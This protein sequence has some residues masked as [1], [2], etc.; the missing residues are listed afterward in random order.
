MKVASNRQF[1]SESNRVVDPATA[2]AI[3]AGVEFGLSTTE[4]VQNAMKAY[5]EIKGMRL[6]NQLKAA[7]IAKTISDMACDAVVIIN[8]TPF[9]VEFYMY[10]KNPMAVCPDAMRYGGQTLL[11]GA[12]KSA[13]ATH[14]YYCYKGR[15]LALYV[16]NRKPLHTANRGWVMAW[17]GATLEPWGK[18]QDFKG[19]KV[20]QGNK[21]A[22]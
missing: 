5:E 14:P 10:N 21:R 16:D 17:D 20:Q 8:F 3:A 6:D 11:V 18:T 19:V 1:A 7:E 9:P 2:A 4:K 15:D 12:F 22:I 13:M